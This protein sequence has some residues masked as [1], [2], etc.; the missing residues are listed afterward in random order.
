MIIIILIA[1]PSIIAIIHLFLKSII[2]FILH[3]RRSFFDAIFIIFLIFTVLILTKTVI[4]VDIEGW[5]LLQQSSFELN[6]LCFLNFIAIFAIIL[7]C[8]ISLI[9]SEWFVLQNVIQFNC[10]RYIW[11]RHSWLDVTDASVVVIVVLNR[12][13]WEIILTLVVSDGMMRELW[14]NLGLLAFRE[15]IQEWIWH[16][17]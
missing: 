3:S 14:K 13:M 8:R 4:E 1:F 10:F 15:I 9:F 17:L 16:V 11:H 12:M 5:F 7:R 6:D 2:W